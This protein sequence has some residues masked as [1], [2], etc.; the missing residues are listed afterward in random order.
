VSFLIPPRTS[1]EKLTSNKNSTAYGCRVPDIL[2]QPLMQKRCWN[3]QRLLPEGWRARNWTTFS[4][5]IM[6]ALPSGQ[7]VHALPHRPLACTS[8]TPWSLP[9]LASV[10]GIS[11]RC[12]A[13]INRSSWRLTGCPTVK[14]TTWSHLPKAGK[15]ASRTR[16]A[17]ALLTTG[18]FTMATS[19]ASLTVS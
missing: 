5:G 12:Q 10:P 1:F 8:V 13:A 19:A 11:A 3:V 16:R 14:S 4:R 17:C 2:S 6:R 7:R 15:T 18:R 9:F